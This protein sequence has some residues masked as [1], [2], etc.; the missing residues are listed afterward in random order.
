MGFGEAGEPV[1]V[2]DVQLLESACETLRRCARGFASDNH[3][4]E[5][6]Q[7]YERCSHGLR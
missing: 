2:T 7:S 1:C 6:A 4:E 5:A 3:R